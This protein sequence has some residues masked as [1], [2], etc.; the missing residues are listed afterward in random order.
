MREPELRQAVYRRMPPG[1]ATGCTGRVFEEM[2]LDQGRA[3]IDIVVAAKCLRGIELKSEADSLAR[4]IRQQEIYSRYFEKMTLIADVRHCEAAEAIVPSWWG[5][6]RAKRTSSGEVS[7]RR[8]RPDGK[9]PTISHY[10]LVTL[11]WEP[12]IIQ[13]MET[14]LGSA[15]GWRGKPQLQLW[16]KLYGSLDEAKITSIVRQKLRERP[17]WLAA[18]LLA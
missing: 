4:L 11:L 1:Y 8:V 13:L 10:H 18:P 9:N 17:A 16:H 2:I 12:E 6:I 5:I 3:R 7:L 15:R 14:H